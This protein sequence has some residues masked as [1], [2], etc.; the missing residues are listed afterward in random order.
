MKNA[1]LEYI[2]NLSSVY[3]LSSIEV[4]DTLKDTLKRVYSCGEI[5]SETINGNL[6]FYRVYYNRYNEL[7]KEVIKVEGF[8][9]TTKN[10]ART[11][12]PVFTREE[13]AVKQFTDSS[14]FNKGS[15]ENLFAALIEN[16]DD[17][18]VIDKLEK[19]LE[20]KKQELKR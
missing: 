12:I 1:S 11:F 19:M 5:E 16:T 20:R 8:V 10:Y 17:P 13:Y 7:K 3:D 6:V 14:E 9:K 2:K 15:K 4:V 18:Q